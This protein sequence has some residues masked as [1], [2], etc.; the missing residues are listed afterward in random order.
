MFLMKLVQVHIQAID[1]NTGEAPKP[2]KNE[3]KISVYNYFK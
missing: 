3:I 2:K 1:P